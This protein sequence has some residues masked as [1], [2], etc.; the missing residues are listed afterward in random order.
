M[1][2]DVLVCKNGTQ[3]FEK[4]EV[5]DDYFDDKRTAIEKREEAYNTEAIIEWDNN[6]ITVSH[7]A[8]LWYYYA[9]ENSPKAEELQLLIIDAKNSIREKYPDEEE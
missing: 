1:I 4:K 3:V 9:A 2:I 7:A 8:Q 6:M 5:P